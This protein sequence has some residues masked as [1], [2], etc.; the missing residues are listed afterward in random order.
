[1]AHQARLRRTISGYFESKRPDM[2][3]DTEA[4]RGERASGE[5]RRA[6]AGDVLHV[7][8]RGQL[9][10]LLGLDLLDAGKVHV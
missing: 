9:A 8:V 2:Q 5:R 10:L 3:R 6:V 7:G 1:M 4:V